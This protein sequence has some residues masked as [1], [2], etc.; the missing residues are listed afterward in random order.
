MS[1]KWKKSSPPT[2]PHNIR[3]AGEP[4][5][6]SGAIAVPAFPRLHEFAGVWA[7]EPRAGST[8][9]ESLQRIDLAAH[10]AKGP[11]P[12]QSQLNKVPASAGRSIAVIRIVGTLMKQQ[13]SMDQS[14]SSV[15]LRRDIRQAAA[16]PEVSGILLVIDSP[17]GTVAGTHDLAR[18]VK[19]ASK[20]KP[21]YAQVEDLCASA[22]YWIASQ[23][24]KIFANSPT[25]LVGNVGTYSLVYDLSG[26]AE[27]KGIKA[28]LFATGPLK[29]AGAEGTP[30]TEE[31]ASYFQSIVDTA[32]VSFDEAVRSGRGLTEKQLGE[33]RSGAIYGG[34]E[35]L[36]RK[37]IDGLQSYE[38]TLANLISASRKSKNTNSERGAAAPPLGMEAR[39][40]SFEQWLDAQFGVDAAD[41]SEAQVAKFQAM[42]QTQQN[43]GTLTTLP[44]ADEAAAEHVAARRRAEADETRRVTAI[45]ATCKKYGSPQ[46]TLDAGQP[47]A[48]TVD[49]EAHAIAENWTAERTELECLRASRPTTGSVVTKDHDRDCTLQA[50]QAAM[51]LRFGG[52]LDHPSYQT[53]DAIAI[54]VSPW[55]RAGLNDA[56]RNRAMEMAHRYRGMSAVDVCRESLRLAGQ[57]IPH[58]RDDLIRASFSGGTL[59]N[60]FTDSVNARL[61]ATYA[62]A[63]D[64]TLGW[65]QETEVADFKVNKDISLVKGGAI[66]RRPRGISAAHGSRS[67]EAETYSVGSYSE[68][69]VVT[70]EDIVDDMLGAIAEMP[71]EMANKCARLRPDLVYA[72][73]LANPTLSATARELFNSTDDNI[74]TTS[75]LA[76]ATLKTGIA[77]MNV[78]QQNGVNLNLTPTHLIVPTTLRFTAAELLQSAGILI[79]WGADDETLKERGNKNVLADEGITLVSDAR[80]ENG[81]T[82]PN[83]ETA[84]SGSTSTWYLACALARTILVAYLRGRGRV[85]RIRSGSLE[86]G[87]YGMWWDIDFV[88]GAKAR[89]FRGLYRATA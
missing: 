80:L 72:I 62:E 30:I 14:S 9:W 22:A 27:Q 37:L 19:A 68:Q 69:L 43:G 49:I 33:I 88:I 18:D 86:Q 41:L 52:R 60:V 44:T 40:M 2:R 36:D 63:G 66:K 31:Q 81:V 32:Q 47:T 16:D 4:T 79:S 87:E 67:D 29:G 53:P 15:Q 77:N 12:V 75:A 3:A 83:T 10:I 61:L 42:Y 59:T 13:S 65:T 28:L 50:M 11:P 46:F 39:T 51:L 6:P 1:K 17:G 34:Q 7:I 85:P 20:Q 23:C 35:A 70:E 78:K 8:L 73:L 56:A 82:D 58:D 57:T 48:S 21:V 64:T 45:R 26:M 54:K 5:L 25:A 71:V 84:Y 55:L 24:D 74:D 89:E 38:T 76:S